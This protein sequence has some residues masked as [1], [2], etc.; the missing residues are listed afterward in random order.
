MLHL[1]SFLQ[2]LHPDPDLNE[3]LRGLSEAPQAIRERLADKAISLVTT[4]DRFVGS[5]EFL[6]CIM[7]ESLYQAN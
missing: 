2:H 1:A 7:I 4:N 6:E 3:E 5:I